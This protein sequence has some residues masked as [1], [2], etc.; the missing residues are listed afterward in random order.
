MSDILDKAQAL[1]KCKECPW[2]KNCL[3]PMQISAE[4]V[5]QF[6]TMMNGANMPEQVKNDLDRF[7]EGTAASGQ[8]ML[9]QSCPVFTQRL[10]ESP[11]LAQRIK[12]LMLNWGSEEEE[13]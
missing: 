5:G 7:I 4:D 9:L 12:D 11:R 13:G 6:R 3:T 8:N 10:K 1:I 2:Y